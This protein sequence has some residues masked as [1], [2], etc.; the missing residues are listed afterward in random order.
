MYVFGESL[1]SP[2][3]LR[4]INVVC[5]DATECLVGIGALGD[6]VVGEVR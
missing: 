1:L 2:G 3:G 4:C 6:G 5:P